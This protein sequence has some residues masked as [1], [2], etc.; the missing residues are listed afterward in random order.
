MDEK[1]I[2]HGLEVQKVLVVC[3]F[4]V[5]C[6]HPNTLIVEPFSATLPK[7]TASRD[8]ILYIACCNLKLDTFCLYFAHI[9]KY[10]YPYLEFFA[11]LSL[12]I[13]AIFKYVIGYCVFWMFN[14]AFSSKMTKYAFSKSVGLNLLRHMKGK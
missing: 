2:E 10:F 14:H 1:S 7:I 5:G 6:H 3:L 13:S 8:H 4:W 11:W 9:W 12:V